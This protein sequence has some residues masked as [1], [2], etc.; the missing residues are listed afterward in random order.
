[1]WTFTW[2]DSG[3]YPKPRLYLECT[4]LRKPLRTAGGKAVRDTA[5]PV[6]RRML[7]TCRCSK[8]LK[9]QRHVPCPDLPDLSRFASQLP[10]EA[11]AISVYRARLLDALI[12]LKH[13]RYGVR[14]DLSM[15]SVSNIVTLKSIFLLH[16]V[17]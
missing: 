17:S 9:S 16:V 2:I 15:I 11:D 1:M 5:F 6:K 12:G 4:R 10:S 7:A 3:R 13:I 8:Y 14:V